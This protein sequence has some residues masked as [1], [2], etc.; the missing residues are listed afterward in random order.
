MSFLKGDDEIK[1]QKLEKVQHD[2][3]IVFSVSFTIPFL[4]IF[5]PFWM[6]WIG[7]LWTWEHLRQCLQGIV[8]A[9]SIIRIVKLKHMEGKHARI[10]ICCAVFFRTLVLLCIQMLLLIKL[11]EFLLIED[12]CFIQFTQWM[13]IIKEELF[14]FFPS[15]LLC[16]LYTG[17]HSNAVVKMPLLIPF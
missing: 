11:Q 5:F 15:S 16:P 10:K 3:I 9:C 2:S 7:F 6:E 12:I 13:Q 8:V 14:I 1:N 4:K 17:W